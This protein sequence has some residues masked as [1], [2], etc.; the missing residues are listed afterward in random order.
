[1]L[2]LSITFFFFSHL[3][4][5]DTAYSFHLIPPNLIMTI[6]NFLLPFF[7]C[8]HLLVALNNEMNG[9]YMGH[10]DANGQKKWSHFNGSTCNGNWRKKMQ[11]SM[12]SAWQSK[13]IRRF[14]TA[15]NISIK[16]IIW[17]NMV[18]SERWMQFAF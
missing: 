4:R 17:T 11:F 2:S 5:F 13:V 3:I 18:S 1:M 8:R 16:I 7:F 10:R 9:E 12:S 14:S 6:D 15:A